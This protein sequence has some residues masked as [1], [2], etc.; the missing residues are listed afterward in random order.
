V[1]FKAGEP[2]LVR[3]EAGD[4]V[5]GKIVEALQVGHRAWEYH[6]RSDCGHWLA[7]E[8]ATLYTDNKH[9]IDGAAKAC[10]NIVKKEKTDGE[11]ED[12]GAAEVV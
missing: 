10:K 5:D 4:Y 3:T 7:Y 9:A 11:G 1:I 12:R 8:F 6:A 2:V